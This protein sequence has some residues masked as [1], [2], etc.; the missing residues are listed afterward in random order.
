VRPTGS[1]RPTGRQGCRRVP[2]AVATRSGV[3][4]TLRRRKPSER[5]TTASGHS[6]TCAA[7]TGGDSP[8]GRRSLAAGGRV[9]RAPTAAERHA[10]ERGGQGQPSR[11]RR[12]LDGAPP[13]AAEAAR[14]DRP[15]PR[16]ARAISEVAAEGR[17]RG[18]DGGY[19]RGRHRRGHGP[20]PSPRAG[21]RRPR[22]R[23]PPIAASAAGVATTPPAG[24]TAA[25]TRRA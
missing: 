8:R 11:R 16:R 25:P 22:G 17:C 5:P 12:R 10:V 18:R 6:S 9:S 7:S 13:R 4:P 23:P 14:A 1:P 24:V 19:R 15:P 2:A 20:G 21:S 3:V